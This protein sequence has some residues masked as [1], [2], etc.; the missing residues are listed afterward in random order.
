MKRLWLVMLLLAANTA[1]AQVPEVDQN[2]VLRRGDAVEYVAGA[3][4]EWLVALGPPADD[5]DKWFITVVS[6]QG[7]PGCQKLKREWQTNEWLQ[8]LADP[9]NP[10]DSWAH[11]NFYDKD[12]KSQ[13]WRFKKIKLEAFPT[14]IV[15][16]PRNGRYGDPKTIV[17]QGI[18]RGDPKDLAKEIVAAIRKYVAKL[19]PRASQGHEQLVGVDPPWDPAPK[20]EPEP[21]PTPAVDPLDVLQIPPEVKPAPQLEPAPVLD[22]YP[23]AVVVT[24]SFDGLS[25]EVHD[26]IRSILT[27]LEARR[28]KSLKIRFMDWEEA[29]KRFPVQR[30][31]VPVVLMTSNGR[32][33]DKLSARLLPFVETE[34]RQVTFADIPWP[35]VLTLVTTGFSLPAAVA[36]GIFGVRL[37]RAR[38]EKLGKPLLVDDATFQQIL[39]A[40]QA[41]ASTQVKQQSK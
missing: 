38:R 27:G 25:P 1:Q 24:D 34:P 15:Q 35:A 21:V 37:I 19:K 16:P 20:V 22:G 8:S 4:G 31:E 40:L 28:G 2:E 18:Y 23:E 39:A 30:D 33:E 12:D 41:F 29:R 26:R 11:F 5:R 6:M 14:I 3:R 9:E 13:N 10:K 32:I 36:I 7:C 17:F